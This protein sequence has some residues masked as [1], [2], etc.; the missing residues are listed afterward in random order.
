MRIEL[1]C[2]L[3]GESARTLTA[4]GIVKKKITAASQLFYPS[5]PGYNETIEHFIS[6]STAYSICSVQPG[7]AKD[8]ATIVSNTRNISL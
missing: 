5:D 2:S 7:T 1:Y 3:S 4:C 6:S 8:V